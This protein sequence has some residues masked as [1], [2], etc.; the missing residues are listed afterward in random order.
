MSCIV[1]EQCTALSNALEMMM[2]ERNQTDQN[3]NSFMFWI[4]REQEPCSMLLE[5]CRTPYIV[6]GQSADSAAST[7]DIVESMY[8]HVQPDV[9]ERHLFKY[10]FNT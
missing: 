10:C 2:E 8:M 9:R 5:F 4:S 1:I 3:A 6:G 7:H